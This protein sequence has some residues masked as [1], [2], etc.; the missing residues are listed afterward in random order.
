MVAPTR[1][2]PLIRHATAVARPHQVPAATDATETEALGPHVGEARTKQVLT[3]AERAAPYP[4][5]RPP[6]APDTEA[7]TARAPAPYRV[8]API[9]EVRCRRVGRPEIIEAADLATA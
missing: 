1:P 5:V 3:D 2:T 4:P 7:A 8:T 6:E 9:E